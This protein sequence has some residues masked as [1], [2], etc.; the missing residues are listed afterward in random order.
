[1]SVCDEGAQRNAASVLV[2]GEEGEEPLQVLTLLSADECVVEHDPRRA[3]PAGRRKRAAHLCAGDAPP[4]ASPRPVDLHLELVQPVEVE[5]AGARVANESAKAEVEKTASR[6]S[7]AP[8]PG[9]REDRRR[10]A[11]QRSQAPRPRGDVPSLGTRRSSA[12]ELARAPGDF[13]IFVREPVLVKGDEPVFA[14]TPPAN[15]LR[16]LWV[17]GSRDHGEVEGDCA[18][19]EEVEKREKA[20]TRP[21]GVVVAEEEHAGRPCSVQLAAKRTE[22]RSRAHCYPAATRP[23]ARSGRDS[24]SLTH[25]N[26]SPSPTSTGV[27]GRKPRSRRAR[28]ISAPVSRTSPRSVSR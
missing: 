8:V 7:G 19:R 16:E 13:V 22:P 11:E 15:T 12:A 3:L 10:L 24:C 4:V 5:P 17:Q 21:A 27:A 6:R 9:R 18:A 23:L 14:L 20:A 28:T 2:R 25:S 1:V 26:S